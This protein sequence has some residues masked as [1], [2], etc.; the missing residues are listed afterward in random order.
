MPECTDDFSV[1]GLH[2]F[3]MKK[4]ARLMI[5]DKTVYFKT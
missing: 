1:F 5:L 4:G 2:L 3:R